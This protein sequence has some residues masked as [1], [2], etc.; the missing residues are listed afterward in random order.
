MRYQI[1]IFNQYKLE[2]K[3]YNLCPKC[4]HTRS[5]RNQKQKCLMTDWETGL[6]TCQHCGVVLQ[7]HK[8]KNVY[9]GVNY[10]FSEPKKINRIGT[11]HSLEFFNKVYNKYINQ[12]SNFS[13]YLLNYFSRN[14]IIEARKKLKIFSTNDF[15]N[16][17]TC[18]PYINE[19]NKVTGIKIMA[20]DEYGN[21][22]KNRQGN[23]VVNWM[24]SLNKIEGWVNS[25]CLFGLHQI[26]DRNLKSVHIVESEKTA[27][28]MTIVKPEYLW[29]ATGGLT[30]LNKEKL[31]PIKDYKIV[32]HPDKGNAYVE[33]NKLIKPLKC[34][35][36]IVSRV[37]EDNPYIENNGDLADYYLVKGKKE[38]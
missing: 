10:S 11:Y 36:I 35:D 25:F 37:T 31:V 38:S 28:V 34:F 17:S 12:E 33:W 15:Y 14:Q 3:K 2:E 26:V 9:D 29:L 21:R 27:F 16:K 19:N 6:A 20:Y 23:G 24:H 22:R 30:M 8:Y 32:L 1:E 5:K 7:L 18:Y 4:S 13:E